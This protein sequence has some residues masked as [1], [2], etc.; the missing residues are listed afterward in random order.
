MTMWDVSLWTSLSYFTGLLDDDGDDNTDDG[1]AA[2]AAA[3]GTRVF[4]EIFRILY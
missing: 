3:V 2:A 1:I 4:M